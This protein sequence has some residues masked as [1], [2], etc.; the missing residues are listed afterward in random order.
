MKKFIWGLMSI[1]LAGVVVCPANVGAAQAGSYGEELPRSYATNSQIA[2]SIYNADLFNASAQLAVKLQG[3]ADGHSL[4]YDEM[5]LYGTN[6]ILYSVADH[7]NT[8][9]LNRNQLSESMKSMSDPAAIKVLSMH[10]KA[11]NSYVTANNYLKSYYNTPTQY[12]L[13]MYLKY[14]KN[15][16]D[17]AVQIEDLSHERYLYY[18]N[19]ALDALE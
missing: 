13:N 17:L 11:I 12:N 14:D 8:Y 9:K 16:Y 18:L 4:A 5:P 19:K 2:Q 3:V 1:A 6:E 7:L 10:L 15:A